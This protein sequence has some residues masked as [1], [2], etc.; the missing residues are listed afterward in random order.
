MDLNRQILCGIDELEQKRES[1]RT[2]RQFF[3]SEDSPRRLLDQASQGSTRLGSSSHHRMIS[4]LLFPDIGDLPALTD[5][6]FHR[7]LGTQMFEQAAPTPGPS[8]AD[9]V[10]LQK[11][12]S[13]TQ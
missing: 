11:S 4:L 1:C 12:S 3:C 6:F 10:K 5:R 13:S 7:K 2:V 9:G 8:H